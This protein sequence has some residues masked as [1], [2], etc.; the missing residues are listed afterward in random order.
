MNKIKLSK[1][2]LNTREPHAE[3]ITRTGSQTF[4]VEHDSGDVFEGSFKGEYPDALK[5][6]PPPPG[7]GRLMFRVGIEFDKNGR[8]IK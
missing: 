3:R 8:V 7:T 4:Q 5:G 6:D 2:S 1:T